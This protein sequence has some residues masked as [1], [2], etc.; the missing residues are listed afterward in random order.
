MSTISIEGMTFHAFH[1]CL[2]E[3][4]VTGNTFIVDVYLDTDTTK[5]EKSDDLNDTVNYST[6][7][8][9]VKNEM[10]I[11]SKLLEHVGRRILNA[12][13]AE[14]PEIESAKVKVAKMNPPIN[15]QV[16][17]VSVSL[18]LLRDYPM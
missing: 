11:N 10:I 12:V 1:G 9:T 14:F 3:E 5:A 13:K 6:V 8:E 15:G 7:Y 17:R 18:K 2:P 4:M 16:E